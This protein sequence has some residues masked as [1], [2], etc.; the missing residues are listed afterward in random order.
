MVTQTE[1]TS[2]QE[3]SFS[4]FNP[5]SAASPYPLFAQLRASGPIVPVP[6]PYALASATAW[7]VTQYRE[8]VDVLKD[9]RYIE[10]LRPRTQ[11]I[12]DELLDRVQARGSMD[13]V[14][15]YRYPLPINVISEMLGVPQEQ[16]DQMRVWSEALTSGDPQRHAQL[17]S[18]KTGTVI[19]DEWTHPVYL[20]RWHYDLLRGLAY[21]ARAGA[22]PDPRLEDALA[23]LQQRRQSD[24]RWPRGKAYA[25]REF[26]TMEPAGP[27]RW[28]T[29]RALRVL[30][31]WQ[32]ASHAQA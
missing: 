19:R 30:R 13:V 18:D 5:E 10:T 17:R 24:G 16:R 9:P 25:G 3:P 22:R 1:Q 26:F 11:Q 6:V 31:W 32:A 2:R 7:L 14:E 28:N 29:L 20:H 21:F 8:A 12:A 23:V 27:S 15:D 4:I